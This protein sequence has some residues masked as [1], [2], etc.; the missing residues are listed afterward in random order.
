MGFSYYFGGDIIFSSKRARIL[1]A[2]FST[3]LVVFFSVM[4]FQSMSTGTNDPQ[5]KE[6]LYSNS[7]VP[8]NQNDNIPGNEPVEEEPTFYLTNSQRYF[9]DLVS[10]GST[11][12]LLLGTEPTGFNFDTIMVLS[13]DEAEKQVKIISF[14]R[15]IYI[16]Y[17][18]YV[19]DALRKAKPSY[20]KEKGIYRINAVPS[21]GDAIGYQK[22]TGRFG[23]PYV[24][25]I[26]D[27]INEVFGIYVN[28]FAYVR[29]SGFRT[30][31]DYFGGVTVYVPVLMNYNDPYQDLSIYIE[32]GT[33]HL[34]GRQAEGYVRFRQGFDENGEFHNYGDIFRKQNQNRFIKAFISQHV[35]LKN[36]TKL[37]DIANII[38]SNVI[39]S[40]K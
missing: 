1:K 18:D 10:K 25:F 38:S 28:D 16:D 32:K 34:N 9:E 31:V 26:A 7:P 22:N 37:G 2:F 8:T 11:N 13:V 23:R 5:N 35:T 19:I 17:S 40:V 33:Q 14:P 21:I 6:P 12:I 24:D 29:T 36:L 30:I 39:T 27:I 20:L 15:D 3:I 4:L